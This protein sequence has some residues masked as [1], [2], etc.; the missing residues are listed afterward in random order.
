MKEIS[1]HAMFAIIAFVVLSLNT[2][3]QTVDAKAII[4]KTS[5]VYK[6]WEGMAVKFTAHVHSD[7][8]GISES[9]EGTIVMKDNKFVL[10]TPDLTTWF[11]GATQW[12]YM[13]RTGEVNINTPSGSDLRFLNPMILLQ[14]YQED[15]NVSYIGESTS[16]NAKMAYDVALIPKKK[17]DIEKIEIQIEK[18]ASLPVKLVVT[19]RNDMRNVIHVKELKK[20]SPPDDLFTFPKSKYPDVEIIDLR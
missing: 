3:A 1:C 7:K 20:D 15:F 13:P 19:M 11:D 5:Q 17:D 10:T 18:N 8:N 14:D 6:E 4:G 2:S 12:T 16:A 9:F